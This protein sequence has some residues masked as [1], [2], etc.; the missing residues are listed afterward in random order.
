ENLNT[1]QGWTRLTTT[2]VWRA[3]ARVSS[4]RAVT[5][6]SRTTA[7][8]RLTGPL[9]TTSTLPDAHRPSLPTVSVRPAPSHALMTSEASLYAWVPPSAHNTGGEAVAGVAAAQASRFPITCLITCLHL[10][11]S[12]L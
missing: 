6:V 11:T 1:D 5:P 4:T 2:F 10:I 7:L 3:V 9:D 12:S 8:I